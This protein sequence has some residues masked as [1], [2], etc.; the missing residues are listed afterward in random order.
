MWTCIQ[1]PRKTLPRKTDHVI[2]NYKVNVWKP[3]VNNV[4]LFNIF[5]HVSQKKK[6]IQNLNMNHFEE[7]PS[8]QHQLLIQ[9]NLCLGEVRQIGHHQ[10][11]LQQQNRAI[12]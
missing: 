5:I 1:K 2:S 4:W 6:N 7:I 3:A 11:V 10:Q 9:S 12:C 8:E